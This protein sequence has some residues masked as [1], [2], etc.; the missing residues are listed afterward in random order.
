[1]EKNKTVK[2][3]VIVIFILIAALMGTW[4]L[5]GSKIDQYKQ[6]LEKTDTTQIISTDTLYLE[7]TI[8]DTV[9][10]YINQVIFKTDTVYR[11]KGDSIEAEPMIITLKK[12]ITPKQL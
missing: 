11:Q 8:T 12:K 2:T 10:K 1:M 4:M 5:F 6:L 3:L 7:K 9:P